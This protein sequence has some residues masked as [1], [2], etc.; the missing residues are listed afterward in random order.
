MKFECLNAQNLNELQFQIEFLRD[1][2]DRKH[3][4]TAEEQERRHDQ[5]RFSLAANKLNPRE[6]AS[7]VGPVIT[8]FQVIANR[9]MKISESRNLASDIEYALNIKGVTV[10]AK[11]GGFDIEM[12]NEKPSIVPLKDIISR[13]EF[14]NTDYRLPLAVGAD[15]SG[16][17]KIIDLADAP[18][19]LVGG[20]IN[21]GKTT[22][23][24]SMIVSLMFAK[25]SDDVRFVLIGPSISELTCM[26]A[27]LNE[28][29]LPDLPGFD[30]KKAVISDTEL[31]AKVLEA[32]CA[33][34]ENRLNDRHDRPNIVVVIDEYGNLV[35]PGV[36]SNNKIMNSII[37][38][39]RHGKDAGIHLVISTCRPSVYIVTGPIKANFPTRIS[40]RTVSMIDSQT[41]LNS[42]GAE[43]L[44]GN[45]DSLY[46]SETE[47]QRLQSPY[48]SPEE[49]STICEK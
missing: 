31:A 35:R 7:I 28:R 19:I 45:G 29:Y 43:K 48:I 10:K 13:N 18:N 25:P 40:F 41:V 21:Q 2:S 24:A 16:K 33:E 30:E 38:L 1:Y 8:T 36:K 11:T 20:S 3:A 44:I 23:L 26:F 4:V 17:P 6:I 27:N 22:A 46:S 49:V 14:R 5:I 47:L 37:H 42:R 34:M 9:K 39:A 32:L 12:P 15:A